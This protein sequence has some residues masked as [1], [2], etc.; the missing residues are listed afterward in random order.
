[1][2]QAPKDEGSTCGTS[3][4]SAGLAGRE[5]K[6]MDKEAQQEELQ[7]AFAEFAA[8]YPQSALALIIGLFV[9]LLEYSIEKHGGDKAQVIKIDGCGKR[10]ITVHAVTANDLGNRRAAFGASVLTD[11]LEGN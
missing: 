11:G 8:E 2:E 7:D 5:V 1:M 10:D 9:G 3:A 6:S 4:L